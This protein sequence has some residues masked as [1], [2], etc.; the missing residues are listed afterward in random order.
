RRF[1]LDSGL[2]SLQ[3]GGS[4]TT[5]PTGLPPLRGRGH[6]HRSV[7]PFLLATHSDCPTEDD[8]AAAPLVGGANQSVPSAVRRGDSEVTPL[9]ASRAA[10]NSSSSGVGVVSGCSRTSPT[11]PIC[12]L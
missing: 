11:Y 9:N 3:T 10:T 7:Q 5:S 8:V 4:L 12:G 6:Q 1:P 2:L